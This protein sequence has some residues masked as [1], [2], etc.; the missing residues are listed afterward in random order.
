MT[1]TVSIVIP[2]RDQ[3]SRWG[4]VRVEGVSPGGGEVVV[5]LGP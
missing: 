1:V 5:R 2:V 4:P 3:A